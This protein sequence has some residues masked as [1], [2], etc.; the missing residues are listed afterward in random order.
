[1]TL[2]LPIGSNFSKSS[3]FYGTPFPQFLHVVCEHP[4]IAETLGVE[5]VDT[6][7]QDL[8]E[9]VEI[10]VGDPDDLRL[11]LGD[12]GSADLLHAEDLEFR[13]EHVLRPPE[14]VAMPTDFWPDDVACFHR[15]SANDTPRLFPLW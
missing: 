13:R 10:A 8:R 11:D 7:I 4:R 12:L 6:D 14:T 5:I 3:F 1:M 15:A 9:V 2:V